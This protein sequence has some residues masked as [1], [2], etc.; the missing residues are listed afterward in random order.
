MIALN[1]K[2]NILAYYYLAKANDGLKNDTKA[3]K[4]FV[5]RFYV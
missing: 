3:V 4:N 5:S 2:G 1:D